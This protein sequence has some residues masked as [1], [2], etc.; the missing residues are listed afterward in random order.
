ME[1]RTE[2]IL[3]IG[4]GLIVL[5]VF[6]GSSFDNISGD[7][8]L[9]RD[10]TRT[11]CRDSDGGIVP[12]TFG[13]L[14]GVSSNGS[15]RFPDECLSVRWLKEGYCRSARGDPRSVN[16]DCKTYLPNGF[17]RAGACVG[18]TTNITGFVRFTSR[19][20]SGASA[21]YRLNGQGN[22]RSGGIT[23]STVE[24]APGRYQGRAIKP[25]FYNRFSH[26]WFTIEANE[27]I[28]VNFV[29]NQTHYSRCLLNKTGGNY[30]CNLIPGIGNIT[31]R[32]IGGFCTP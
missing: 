13:V 23:P 22:Y 20:E 8:A 18:N 31:C 30:T 27:Q 26:E 24:L 14:T 19:P 9:K 17:C 25:P 7:V 28:L 2:N 29:L 12:E 10:L 3:L 6:L 16:V 11:S 32:N 4:V 21:S 5:F 1:K 15:F